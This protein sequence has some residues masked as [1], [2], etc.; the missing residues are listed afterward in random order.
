MFITP[1]LRFLDLNSIKGAAYMW[2]LGEWYRSTY[3]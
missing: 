1:K 3:L 2:N